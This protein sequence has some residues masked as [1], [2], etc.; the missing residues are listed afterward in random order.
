M[1]PTN[2]RLLEQ[3]HDLC[4][5]ALIKQCVHQV[6]RPSQCANGTRA[7]LR[8]EQVFGEGLTR[9]QSRVH[10]LDLSYRG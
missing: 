9:S 2:G 8:R 1:K 7:F 5:S 4:L 3:L 6:Q 10:D